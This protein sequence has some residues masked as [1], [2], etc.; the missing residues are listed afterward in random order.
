MVI[1]DSKT[2]SSV[3]IDYREVAP[4]LSTTDMFNGSETL[5]TLVSLNCSVNYY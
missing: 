2:R 3:A 5:S 1:Y 4:A